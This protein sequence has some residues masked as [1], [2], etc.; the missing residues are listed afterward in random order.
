MVKEKAKVIGVISI[1]GGVGKTS[2]VTSLGAAMAYEL[3][4]K[5]LVIDANF[6]APNLGLHFGLVDPEKTLHDVLNNK[7][8]PHEALYEVTEG[9]HIMPASMLSKKTKCL[10]LKKKV[11]ELKKYYDVILIDSSPTLNEEILATMMASDELLVVSSPDYPTLYCTMHAM[12]VA[13]QKKTP[14]MGLVLNRVKNKNF[15]LSIA[16]I[17]EAAEAPVLAVIPDD[18]KMLESLSFT[19]PVIVHSP[20]SAAAVEYKKLAATLT[21]QYYKDP[22]ILQK[23]RGLFTK[24]MPIEEVNR[25]LLMDKI[26]KD[27][28]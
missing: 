4:K 18:I 28:E 6:S 12:K 8:K 14:I 11:N 25:Y 15:E 24:N 23:V 17:E 10:A 21:G 20:L 7:I 2:C 3:G 26:K 27:N 13:K 5:T 22:R 19:T 1:K 9:L 16:D